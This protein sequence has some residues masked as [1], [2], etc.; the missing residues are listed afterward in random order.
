MLFR[1][2]L[3]RRLE[4]GASS[5]NFMS[6]VFDLDSD[7]ELFER[8]KHRFLAS[9]E[10]MDTEIPVPSRGQDRS[11]HLDGDTPAPV[12]GFANTPDTDPSLP[13][14]RAWARQ[15]LEAIPGSTL[16]TET[17]DAHRVT[18][19]DGA[20]DAIARAEEAGKAWRK[21][22]GEQR[23]EAL[24]SVGRALHA[25]RGRLLEEIGRAHV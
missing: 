5:E 12:D 14:N 3:V 6:A 17:V 25:A 9:L 21:L 13:G 24:D 7:P 2:Y 23:A 18:T 4:E 10:Q 22:S 16:G 15:I 8:E 11:R 20:E 19:A 1:S